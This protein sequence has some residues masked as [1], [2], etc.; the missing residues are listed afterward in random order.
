MKY[1]DINRKFTEIVAGYLKAGCT[2]NTATMVGNQGE[3]A[4]IDLNDGDNTIRILIQQFFCKDNFYNDG[5][6]IV[7][8]NT[9]RAVR[10]DQ[11]PVNT[12][13]MIWNDRLDVIC[14]EE[15]YQIDK[16]YGYPVWFGTRD[17][18]IAAR[19]VRTERSVQDYCVNPIRKDEMSSNAVKIAERYIRRVTGI[20]HPNRAKLTVR[21]AIRRDGW[22]IYGQY[23]VIYNGKSYILH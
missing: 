7:V 9:R 16:R 18:A 2:I 3:V 8:G 15:F 19:N 21:H 17:D 4:H 14:R 11:P 12:A 6:E 20:K 13:K 10:A 23:I 5:Y 22:R 1:A